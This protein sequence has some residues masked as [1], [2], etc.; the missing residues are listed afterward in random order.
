MQKS[1]KII[2]HHQTSSKII[3]KHQKSSNII[4]HL[5]HYS[6]SWGWFSNFLGMNPWVRSL[7]H[8]P[9]IVPNFTIWTAINCRWSIAYG[10]YYIYIVNIKLYIYIT[11]LHF[12]D[13]PEKNTNIYMLSIHYL[14]PP[15]QLSSDER[16]K[17]KTSLFSRRCCGFQPGNAVGNGK[18]KG[19]RAVGDSCKKTGRDCMIFQFYLLYIYIWMQYDAIYWCVFLILCVWQCFSI[20]L[21]HT[22]HYWWHMLM[23][24]HL[25]WH[26]HGFVYR[27]SDI[28]C[29]CTCEYPHSGL[30]MLYGHGLKP[31]HHGELP[32]S[33]TGP[34]KLA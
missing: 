1:S 25:C 24:V 5:G 18:K 23:H 12:L 17:S 11:I 8:L 32:N 19:G 27:A 2:K 21:D 30:G 14:N 4:K 16:L 28:R 6:L 33:C 22:L 26:V 31:W 34:L 10:I 15:H 20:P 7:G 3:K 13:Y 9:R 29:K